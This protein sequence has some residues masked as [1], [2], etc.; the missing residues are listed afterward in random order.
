MFSLVRTFKE[1]NKLIEDGRQDEITPEELKTIVLTIETIMKVLTPLIDTLEN[2][3][4]Q[5]L[6]L[7]EIE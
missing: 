3:F 4:G 7:I 5:F 6:E 2:V 1:L